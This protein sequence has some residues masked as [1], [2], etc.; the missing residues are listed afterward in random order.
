MVGLGSHDEN[1][2]RRKEIEEYGGK[3]TAGWVWTTEIDGET[4]GG[5]VVDGDKLPSGTAA[6]PEQWSSGGSGP[7]HTPQ[8]QL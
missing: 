2:G 7:L 3:R 8:P 6:V 1:G 4:F 5:D